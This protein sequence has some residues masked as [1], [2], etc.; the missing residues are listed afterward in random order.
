MTSEKRKYPRVKVSIP[1]EWGR[2]EA[3]EQLGDKVTRLSMGG[4][5]IQTEK[6]T[7]T[8]EILFLRLWEI[9]DGRGVLKCQVIYQLKIDPRFPPIGIGVKFIELEEEEENHLRHMLEFCNETSE[10]LFSTPSYQASEIRI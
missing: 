8:D 3:C 7:Q 1:I 5:F 10:T 9:S 2:T 4:C 6:E